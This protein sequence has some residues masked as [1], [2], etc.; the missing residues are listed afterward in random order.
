[1]IRKKSNLILLSIIALIVT[2]NN[3]L[4]KEIKVRGMSFFSKQNSGNY[5]WVRG[6]RDRLVWE[7][8]DISK[9]EGWLFLKKWEN[10]NNAWGLGRPTE[11]MLIC[12]NK[13]SHLVKVTDWTN[14]LLTHQ[15]GLPN[16]CTNALIFNSNNSESM[17]R[18]VAVQTPIQGQSDLKEWILF[19]SHDGKSWNNWKLI[20]APKRIKKIFEVRKG[21]SAIQDLGDSDKDGLY[22]EW[23]FFQRNKEDQWKPLYLTN[24]NKQPLRVRS[25]LNGHVLAVSY[26]KLAD[27]EQNWSLYVWHRNMKF[28]PISKV[29]PKVTKKIID[30]DSVNEQILSVKTKS[31]ETYGENNNRRRSNHYKWHYFILNSG[32]LMP[33]LNALPISNE[34]RKKYDAIFQIKRFVD[35]RWVAIR[36]FS[37]RISEDR[38]IKWRIFYKNKNRQWKNITDIIPN[39]KSLTIWDFKSTASGSIIGLQDF[40]DSNKNEKAY[41]WLWFIQTGENK[42]EKIGELIKWNNSS[43]DEI[44]EVR[45][46]SKDGLIAINRGSLFEIQDKWYWYLKNSNEKW[47][48]V[49]D[50][51][52]VKPGTI[53]RSIESSIVYNPKDKILTTTKKDN[54]VSI[55]H[56]K[57]DNGKWFLLNNFIHE[58]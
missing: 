32:K 46:Y 52:N 21:I 20:G 26:T 42:W 18:F 40:A 58:K 36:L 38:E 24:E 17:Q 54:K 5:V 12:T 34:V 44:R 3:S 30:I 39:A 23:H 35:N 56:T 29:L 2:L 1:M 25:R 14:P 51:L 33:L 8:S 55:F 27:E 45:N 48:E 16:A 7:V 13:Q 11:Y 28:E 50:V 41:E 47:Q 15:Q 4:A 6:F 53:D 19:N 22:N 31:I 57:S 9:K 10:V 43:F 49:L 37:T